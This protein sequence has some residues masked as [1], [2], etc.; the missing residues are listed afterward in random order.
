MQTIVQIIG[1]PGSGKTTLVAELVR[2][3]SGKGLGVGT[4]KHSSHAYE[5]DKPGKDSHVHRQAGA[6]P[7]AMVN[8]KMAALYLPASDLTRPEK[9]IQTYYCHADLVL[10]EG[11]ISGPYPKIEIWRQNLGTPPC[12]RMWKRSVPWCATGFRRTQKN[13]VPQFLP[14]MISRALPGLFVH[15]PIA[16]NAPCQRHRELQTV[17]FGLILTIWNMCRLWGCDKVL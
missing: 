13:H 2:Y 15:S 16:L 1:Q 5:L 11:W 4:L 14:R 9:L 12:L 17:M 10:I 8:A 3:F 6:S 7:A